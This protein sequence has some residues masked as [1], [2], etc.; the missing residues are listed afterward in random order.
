MKG[1]IEFFV[2]LRDKKFLLNH[3]FIK[4]AAGIDHDKSF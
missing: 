3:K 1:L 2:P 4:L